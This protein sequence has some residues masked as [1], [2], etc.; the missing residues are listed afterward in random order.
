MRHTWSALTKLVIYATVVAMATGLLSLIILNAR[1][2]STI[3]YTARF[4]DASG[5]VTNAEVRI[6]G[7]A[8]GK[9]TGI[10][11]VDHGIAEVTFTVEKQLKIPESARVEVKYKNLIGDRYLSLERAPGPVNKTLPAGATIPDAR[12]KPALNL[13][14]LFGGFRPLFQALQPEQVNRLAENIIQTLQG[15]GG[16]VTELL[17]QTAALT[18]TIADSDKI[19]GKMISNLNRVVGTVAKRDHELGALVTQ[20]QR[21]VSGLAQNRD[22]IGNAITSM[23][24][25]TSSVAGLL[26]EARP[27]LDKDIEHLGVLATT[28]DKHSEDLSKTLHALPGMLRK[29]DRTASYGSWF[30]FYLCS[31]SGSITMPAP[32]PTEVLAY[33]NSATRCRQ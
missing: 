15:E 19:I 2:A 10:D 8:V 7:V 27:A 32:L 29:V 30:N 28:L 3:G 11:M 5:L 4:S 25:L 24:E 9:V 31:V 21:L 20:L 26:D 13:T 23:S 12:T 17:T 1:F 6:A 18:N 22:V 16:T 14:V 33:S